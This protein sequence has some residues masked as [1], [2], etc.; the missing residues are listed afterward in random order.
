MTISSFLSFYYSIS[1]GEILVD[2]IQ[3]IIYQ[4]KKASYKKCGQNI[5]KFLSIEEN[6]NEIIAS[7][8]GFFLHIISS[9]YC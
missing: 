8:E 7:D 4:K 6:R 5:K 1:K 3:D 9:Y 2:V